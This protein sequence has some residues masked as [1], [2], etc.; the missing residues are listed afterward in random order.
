[1][2]R[3]CKNRAPRRRDRLAGVGRRVRVSV[4]AHGTLPSRRARNWNQGK[5][6][7]RSW[8]RRR[9]PCSAASCAAAAASKRGRVAPLFPPRPRG[10]RAMQL[11]R[12]V[13]MTT[14]AA[15][16]SLGTTGDFRPGRVCASAQHGAP[17]SPLTPPLGGRR[18]ARGG[19][20]SLCTGRRWIAARCTGRGG[21]R[22]SGRRRV[23]RHLLGLRRCARA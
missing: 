16:P 21:Q 20:P 6:A 1:M 17:R 13:P 19:R 15:R 4:C 2:P 18:P 10:S 22:G 12:C 23:V 11:R 3:Q 9:A 14:R 7:G 8:A 5:G